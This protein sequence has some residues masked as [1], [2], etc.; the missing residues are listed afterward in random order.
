MSKRTAFVISAVF[1]L[2]LFLSSSP[3]GGIVAHVR[4]T[5]S[6]L[7][8]VMRALDTD[9]SGKGSDSKGSDSNVIVIMKLP[10]AHFYDS[11]DAPSDRASKRQNFN[12][13]KASIEASL[14]GGGRV[15]QDLPIINGLALTVSPSAL[16]GLE[17]NPNVERVEPDLEVEAV[18]DSSAAA[19]NALAASQV[20]D[21]SGNP[22]TGKGV[23]IAIIDT[24][25]DYTNPEL[26][27]CL[28]STC[29]VVGGY[30]FVNNDADPMDD[31]GH[32]T[33]VAATAAGVGRTGTT[34][35]L[36][37]VAPGASILAYKVLNSSGSG[38]FSNVIAGIN[39]AV[40]PNNDGSTADHAD[41]ISMSLGARCGSTYSSSCGPNDS[42]SIAVDNATAA[43]VVSAISA[44][45]SG[46]SA[47]TV[48]S[49]GAAASAITVAAACSPHGDLKTSYCADSNNTPIASFSSRGPVIYQGI[50]YQKPDIAA[51]GVM[52]CA[53]RWGA[54]FSSS[55]TC[56]DTAHVRISGTS[57]AAPHIAGVLALYKQAYPE[58]TPKSLKDL[59]KSTAIDL[60][61]GAT[62]KDEGAGMV[63]ASIPLLV[64][65]PA[66]CNASTGGF[67]NTTLSWT[68]PAS[69]TIQIWSTL[70]SDAASIL[71]TCAN[72][73]GSM[74]SPS[75]KT[76]Y[77]YTFKLYKTT[78]CNVSEIT[79]KMPDASVTV[80]GL[81]P[82][83]TATLTASV[84][85]GAPS[86]NI[87]ASV[88][89]TIKYAW[90]STNGVSS[91]AT[92]TI[93]SVACGLPVSGAAAWITGLSGGSSATLAAC[94]GG[95][96]YTFKYTVT[97]SDGQTAT[98][99]LVVVVK[100]PPPPNDNFATATA[101]TGLSGKVTGNNEAAT[102][103]PSEPNNCNLSGTHS[104]WYAF[105]PTASGKLLIDT[106]SSNFDTTLGV[107]TGSSL[108][109]LKKVACNDDSGGLQSRVS[110]TATSGIA[111]YISVN[112]YSSA[113]GNT[114]LSW[115]LTPSLPT[116]SLTV[117]GSHAI[118]VNAVDSITYAWNSTN[119]IS[120]IG[121][122]SID[123]G[124]ST[125]WTNHA[126]TLAGSTT[127]NLSSLTK[128]G[129][130]YAYKYT[131]TDTL[132]NT[133]SDSATVTI[134]PQIGT[135]NS[136]TSTSISGTASGVYNV[137]YYIATSSGGKTYRSG[138]ATVDSGGLWSRTLS[139]A[140][141]S[142][143]YYVTLKAGTGALLGSSQVFQVT[144]P[145]P[146][147]PK[148]ATIN[149]LTSTSISGMAT[150]ILQVTYTVAT[151]SGGSTYRSGSARVD[152][153]W[154]S[155]AISPA[156]PS[157][158][159]YVTLKA[160]DGSVLVS[161]QAFTVTS[162]TSSS[163]THPNTSA[164]LASILAA[165]V[166][167]ARMVI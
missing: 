76:G 3:N 30:D 119:G 51:P 27:G 9:T 100:A 13:A 72:K 55:P 114:A 85:S 123:G 86:T 60:G 36:S 29:K 45:N 10:S 96:T 135:I 75:I 56:F 158:T 17:H 53:A 22:I 34:P 20:S 150:D 131:V 35:S 112:G 98:A 69:S 78:T 90:S 93:D 16:D 24:G 152:S 48:G 134:R 106:F 82:A 6:Q 99:T 84:G 40:D 44:G 71:L 81:G 46:P 164:N 4:S 23:Q 59:I 133:A 126:N 61:G 11:K 104:I 57:M 65:I 161:S 64:A 162:S 132:G 52:I 32:G 137:T 38:T 80:K 109:T 115:L 12:K 108:S 50:D 130:T 122:Y 77:T 143:T 68:S 160:G 79:G 117:N 88:G 70:N 144:T 21:R 41:I 105:K 97:S 95:H 74:P 14:G 124:P 26:G 49:P 149:S 127:L 148:T 28:G 136:L 66:N 145:A 111:Y 159:Y 128:A 165:F 163:G 102:I 94:E 25:V 63:N 62:Y 73:S 113:V 1:L 33:H 138:I 154:W 101:L 2:L 167:F 146:P 58:S 31:Q 67:C 140:L 37:G 118:T 15:T 147:P 91:S 151:S 83:P 107:Y 39:R 54:S 8:G 103:E 156:L 110:F 7:A 139:P 19:I 121:T 18:L 92:Y 42:V 155:S 5:I 43:G 47:S 157:G 87:T 120:A 89:D 153:G 116:A 142:G 166:S 125:I 129:H 141:P